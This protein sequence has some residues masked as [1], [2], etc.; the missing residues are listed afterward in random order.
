MC[1]FDATK[2]FLR[3][4]L[5]GPD[6][7]SCE[8]DENSLKTMIFFIFWPKYHNFLHFQ[9]LK[10]ISVVSMPLLKVNRT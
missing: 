9:E 2:G 8:T 10:V 3:F 7:R 5:W 4:S 1:A 6:L